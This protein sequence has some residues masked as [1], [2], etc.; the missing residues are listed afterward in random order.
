MADNFHSY[1]RRGDAAWLYPDGVE[2][3]DW[4][5]GND[6]LYS[7]ARDTLAATIGRAFHVRVLQEIAR[8]SQDYP[9]LPLILTENKASIPCS[10]P[11]GFDVS[12]QTERG[13]Y[14]VSLGGW[15]DEFALVSE[16]IELLEAALLGAIR[17]RVDGGYK[18]QRWTAEKRLLNGQWLKLPRHEEPDDCA[19]LVDPARTKVLRNNYVGF[20]SHAV[21]IAMRATRGG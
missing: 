9:G 7:A 1:T 19:V 21:S 18:D 20:A 16:A 5:E 13:H 2:D 6:H 12:I 10:A 8:L 15:S 11:D 3:A 17:L 14:I 4:S